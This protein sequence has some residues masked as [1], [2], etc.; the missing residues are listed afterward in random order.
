[1]N[2]ASLAFGILSFGSG[3]FQSTRAQLTLGDAM[4]KADQSAYA[5][6]VAAGNAAA[7]SAQ[8]L[9]PLK[10]ILPSVRFE[11]GYV[12]TTD[13]I[14]VF[15]TTLRQ[16]TITQANFDPQRLNYPGAV[17]NYQSGIVVEQPIFNADAWTGRRAAVRAADASRATEEWTRLSTRVDVVQAYY[18]AVL[19]SERMVTLGAAARAAHAHVTQAEA[20]VRQGMVTKS[21][22]L[23]ASVRA[24]DMDA[25]LADAE[26]GATS[27]RRQLAVLL[28]RDG[29]EAL[30][31]LDL[32]AALPSGDRIRAVVAGDTGAI[33]SAPRADVRAASR[34]LDAARADVLR[35]RS[36]YLPRLNSFARYDWNSMDRPYGGDRNWTMGILASWNI[37][38]GA[39]DLGDV[40]AAAGRAAAAQAQA[41]AAHA[42]ARLDIEQTRTTL[43]VALIRL[44]IAE[45]AKVQSAEAHRIVDRKYGGGL[46]TVAELLDAQATELQSALALS[47]AGWGAIAAAADRLRALGLDPAALEALN[48][49]GAVAAASVSLMPAHVDDHTSTDTSRTP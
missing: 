47:Q 28:G 19:A 24:S 8:S 23:L 34:G 38:A 32:P 41:E 4:A 43:A 29:S 26:G 36:A 1:M 14:G 9:V 5:N 3:V 17:G 7:R 46:A 15:G 13:P 44:G 2:R 40:Q 21:D 39:S 25:Q 16:R 42:D 35:A 30:K 31:E 49:T 18:G 48:G 22:A 27:A 45:R 11:A 6:R 10:G 20:M 33:A 12:R 37:F